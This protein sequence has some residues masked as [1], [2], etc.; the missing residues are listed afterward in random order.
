MSG[1]DGAIT[2]READVRAFIVSLVGAAFLA[3]SNEIEFTATPWWWRTKYSWK[4]SVP[5][6]VLKT[7]ESASFVTG[8][9]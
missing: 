1:F 4:L 3:P 7:V 6:S 5:I 2:I 9:N 8:N